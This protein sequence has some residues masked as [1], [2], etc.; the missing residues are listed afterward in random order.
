MNSRKEK[1]Y[2]L[3]LLHLEQAMCA[4]FKSYDTYQAWKTETTI[5]SSTKD[6]A[7]IMELKEQGYID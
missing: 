6:W 5:C 2:E 1:H 3:A 4:G 7:E